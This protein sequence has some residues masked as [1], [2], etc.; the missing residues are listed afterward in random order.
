MFEN[1]LVTI[2]EVDVTPDLRQGHVYVSVIGNEAQQQKVIDALE[3][4]RGMIQKKMAQRV[5]LKLTTCSSFVPV[6]PPRC[7]GPVS[8]VCAAVCVRQC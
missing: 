8:S 1:A 5:V 7:C 4:K 3:S 2:N 6:H